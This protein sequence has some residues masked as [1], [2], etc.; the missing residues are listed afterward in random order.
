LNKIFFLSL[1][2]YFLFDISTPSVCS[3]VKLKSSP[4][5]LLQSD[6]LPTFPSPKNINFEINVFSLIVSIFKFSSFKSLSFSLLIF[7]NF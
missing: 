3:S 2:L 7:L 1:F 5:N 6:V 4:F